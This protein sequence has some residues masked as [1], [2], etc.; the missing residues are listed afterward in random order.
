MAKSFKDELQEILTRLSS[1]SSSSTSSKSLAYSTLLHLQQLSASSSADPSFITLLADSSP[2]FLR[3][4]LVDIFD[5]DEE[6][7]AVQALKCLGFMIYHPSILASIKGDDA[8]M[9]VESLVKVITTTKIKWVCNLGVWCISMQ[10]FSTSILDTHL[11][12]LLRATIYGLDNPMGSLSITFEAMQA[13]MKLASSLG[14]KMRNL[15]YIWVPP[16]YR[17]LASDNKREREMSERCLLKVKCIICPPPVSLSKAVVLDLKKKLLDTIE[18]ML[19]HGKKIEA[20]QAWGWFMRLLGPY[21]TNHKRLLNELL[22]LPTQTF[23]DFDPQVQIASLVSWEGLIDA[24]ICPPFDA[25]EISSA[26]GQ[27]TNDMKISGGDCKKI[28]SDGFSKKIKLIM[29]P[30]TG[31]MSSKCDVSVHVSC[32]TTWCYLLHKL[33]SSVSCDSVARMVCQPILEAIFHLG[34]DDRNIWSWNF[35]I[36][37]LDNF[38]LTR[39]GQNGSTNLQKGAE[40]FA[41]SPPSVKCS[42]RHYPIKWSPWDLSQLEFF[43]KMI[44]CLF[45]QGSNA[46]M[47]YELV[48]LTYNAASRL[49]RSLLKSVQNVLRCGLVTYDEVMLC[50][51]VILKFFNE[52][53]EKL[54]SDS[55]HTNDLQ[56]IS[57]QLFYAAT[58]ELEPSIL[59]SPL[60]RVALDIKDLETIEPICEL[61]N[62]KISDVGCVAYM[63]KV[64][65]AVYISILYFVTVI[66]SRV[67]APDYKSIVLEMCRYVKFILSSYDTVEML[68]VFVGL[69]YRHKVPNCLEIWVVVASCLKEY[70]DSKSNHSLFV[71]GDSPG[72]SAVML[73]LNYPFAAY[74]ILQMQ[75]ET[76]RGIEAWKS[77]YVSICQGS[78][79]C[80]L[81]M[82]RDIFAMLNECIDETTIRDDPATQVHQNEKSKNIDFFLLLGNVMI[83]VLEQA[84]LR[85]NNNNHT[86][87]DGDFRSINNVKSSLEFALRFMKIPWVMEEGDL[88]TSFTLASRIL[89]KV[90]NFIG[91]FPLQ[92]YFISFIQITTN[93]L[94]LW[95][96]HMDVRDNDFKDQLQQ[97]WTEILKNLQKSQPVMNFDSSFLKLQVPL[98]EKTLDHP[99]LE[100]SNPS[101]QFWNATYG[102]QINLQYPENLLPILDK[103]SRNGKLTLCRKTIPAPNRYKVS[104]SLNRCS[105][106]VEFVDENTKVY[107]GRKRKHAELTEHQKEV[108]RAQQGRHSDS[109]G[110]GPGIRTY[111]S[112]DFSQDNEESQEESQDIRDAD[113]TLEML[114]RVH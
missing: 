88:Q 37:L 2:V 20:L 47:S 1:S 63:G 35:C 75:L 68:N 79:H 80:H 91:C 72:Y 99:N 15:S 84:I 38:I 4:I 50:L 104:A 97:L 18:E 25:P 22:K 21:L 92:Q 34:P 16:I 42:W 105:K 3:S 32:L 112:V 64:S 69:L 54:A 100:I 13:V 41:D 51:N 85:A 62:L 49:F 5:H 76:K 107:P 60:Y 46:A 17:R 106:R 7:I 28:T 40:L 59:E 58:E 11:Q 82:T 78:Q 111:T 67:D 27:A 110:R 65:P 36:E 98:L 74:P 93:P 96:S 101:I 39:S 94:L 56:K 52:I 73:L 87:K 70:I 48:I 95:L 103:L 108:R 24:L 53:N 23:S 33:D 12:A 89:S 26:A 6:M 83:C 86:S 43:I 30:L 109:I 14:E 90:V 57:L 66:K 77:L 31:I 55:S 45:N 114:Q 113:S 44:H 9:I 71:M 29:T 19:N 61:G 10:Q 102:E 81:T 8:C